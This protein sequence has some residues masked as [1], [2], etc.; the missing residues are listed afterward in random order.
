MK[1]YVLYRD[2]DEGYSP[3]LGVTTFK[4]KADEWS[5]LEWRNCYDEF[6]IEETV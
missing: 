6:E 2:W 4:S 3:P 5:E 1:I